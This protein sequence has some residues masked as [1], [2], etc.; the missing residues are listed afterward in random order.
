MTAT[1]QA[2]GDRNVRLGGN[3]VGGEK[4]WDCRKWSKQALLMDGSGVCKY[5]MT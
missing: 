1:V 2:R 5:S 4:R 3:G